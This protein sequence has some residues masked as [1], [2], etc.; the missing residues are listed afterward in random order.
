[1]FWCIRTTLT[2]DDDVAA[3]LARAQQVRK[4]SR[5]VVVNDG[6]RRGRKQVLAPPPPRRLFETKTV[7]L[8]RCLAGRLDDVA[9]VL[10]MAEGEDFQ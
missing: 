6:L 4:A 1:M 10:A 2:L 7:E 3:L 8:G 9:E 5:K